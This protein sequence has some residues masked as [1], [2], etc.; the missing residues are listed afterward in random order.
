MGPIDVLASAIFDHI[1]SADDLDLVTS[2]SNQFIF[3]VKCIKVA[4]LAKFP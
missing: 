1:W 3:V 2:K 4:N